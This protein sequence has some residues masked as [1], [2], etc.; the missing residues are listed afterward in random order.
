MAKVKYY[1]NPETLS[2]DKVITTTKEKLKKW[3]GM[4]VVSIVISVIYYLA[5]SHFYDTPK[6]RILM[7]QLSNIKFDYQMLAQDLNQ[8]DRILSDI[9]KRDDNI[10]RT[11]LES[12]PIPT[13][14]RQAGF[15][16]VNRYEPL[17]GYIHSGMMIDITK[18]TDI[19]LKQLYVQ[20]LSYDELIDK[21][22]NKEQMALCR[23]AIQPISNKELTSRSS[24][25]GNRRHPIRGGIVFHE[26]IDLSAPTG[27]DIYATGDG[28]VIK[29]A[30]T[31]GGYGNLVIIDHGFGYQTRYGHMH[32][33][34][35]KEGDVVKR[36]QVIG[37]VGN[38]GGSVGP[39]LH[40]EVYKNG[41]HV[42]PI[43]YFYQDLSPDEYVHMVEQSQ[44]NEI[45]ETW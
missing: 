39:H 32:R 8:V 9:Q 24:A 43:D 12:D 20:S 25:Y 23:P 35:V 26:G 19:I 18:H 5:Y 37:A 44:K 36:G 17:E 4:F 10:Y 29:A 40:Y 11:I 3:G 27:A 38:T 28:T 31:S 22:I 42:N 34:W 1:F 14:K 13:S 30:R 15:G 2:Y 33:I 16:G 45:M 7:N 41:R 21:A 6:E